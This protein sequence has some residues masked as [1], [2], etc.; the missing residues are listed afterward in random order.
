MG[1]RRRGSAPALAAG[2]SAAAL[3]LLPVG[4][5]RPAAAGPGDPFD[6][7]SA[8]REDFERFCAEVGAEAARAEIVRCLASHEREL[9]PGCRI[10]VGEEGEGEGDEGE[11]EREAPPRTRKAPP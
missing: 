3:L 1:R 8:C 6:L 11:A 2:L 5:A 9:S 10:A 7:R 4:L